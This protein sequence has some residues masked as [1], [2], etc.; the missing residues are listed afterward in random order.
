MGYAPA[1]IDSVLVHTDWE[2]MMSDRIP[3]ENLSFER[4]QYREKYLVSIPFHYGGLEIDRV[5]SLFSGAQDSNPS[6]RMVD[7]IPD[8]Y[9]FG[10]NV[11]NIINALTTGYQDSWTSHASLSPTAVSPLIW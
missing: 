2:I 8:G 1:T 9:V 11:N 10:Y 6:R 5:K 3:D 4:K 7:N